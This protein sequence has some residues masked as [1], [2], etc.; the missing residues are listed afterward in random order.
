MARISLVYWISTGL[1]SS[2]AKTRYIINKYFLSVKTVYSI[3]KFAFDL[4]SRL[5]YYNSMTI[6]TVTNTLPARFLNYIV[7]AFVYLMSMKKDIKI[8]FENTHTHTHRL[9]HLVRLGLEVLHGLEAVE[10]S[11]EDL[12]DVAAPHQLRHRQ[13]H[14]HA[15]LVQSDWKIVQVFIS[16]ERGP[17]SWGYFAY[18]KRKCV[19]IKYFRCFYSACKLKKIVIYK[20]NFISLNWILV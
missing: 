6:M 16:I 12:S 15:G 13:H 1:A 3:A 11:V 9:T 14:L 2:P 4:T 19:L 17:S 10:V 5:K 18:N 7:W 8:S 20:Y